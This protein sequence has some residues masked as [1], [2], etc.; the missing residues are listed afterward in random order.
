MRRNKVTAYKDCKRGNEY[1][2]KN[3]IMHSRVD[4]GKANWML[5][6]LSQ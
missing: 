2:I 3:L 4:P 1:G 6:W 5:T